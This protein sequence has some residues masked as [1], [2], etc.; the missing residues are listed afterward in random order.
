MLASYADSGRESLNMFL[1]I[2]IVRRRASLLTPSS[3][4][5]EGLPS[6]ERKY[7]RALLTTIDI[8][9]ICSVSGREAG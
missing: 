7:L 2:F 5:A 6:L 8:S 4:T 9:K 3:R 1:P